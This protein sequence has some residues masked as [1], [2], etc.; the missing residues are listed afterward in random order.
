MG[1]KTVDPLDLHRYSHGPCDARI[2]ASQQNA[3]CNQVI[4]PYIATPGCRLSR[5][6]NAQFCQVAGAVLQPHSGLGMHIYRTSVYNVSANVA[7]SL[8]FCHALF[9]MSSAKS[10]AVAS[11]GTDAE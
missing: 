4:Y 2:I 7:Q 3:S 8:P 1:L 11:L 6:I 10:H 5:L 9:L